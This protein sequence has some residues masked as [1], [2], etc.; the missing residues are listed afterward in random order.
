[1]NLNTLIDTIVVDQALLDGT[2]PQVIAARNGMEL[3]RFFAAN[4]RK[5]MPLWTQEEKAFLRSKIGKMTDAQIGAALGRSEAAVK[6]KRQRWGFPAHSKRPGW[7]TGHGAAKILGVDIHN[8]MALCDRRILPHVV[9]P[10][11]RGIL[12]IKKI[13]LYRWAVNPMHWI[14]FR[15]E[16]VRDRHLRRLIQLKS[17][18]WGDEWWTTGQVADYH[19]VDHTDVNR[20]IHAGKIKSVK[21]GNHWILRSEALKPGLYFYKGKGAGHDMDWSEEGDAFLVQARR[22]GLS[23]TVMA[24]LMKMD[25][26]TVGY[27][28]RSLERQGMIADLEVKFEGA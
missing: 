2:P 28:Y 18:R 10:G 6:I 17:E 27:R 26:K 7:V 22:E 1:V 13:A 16:N 11:Q 14:Y 8:I 21:W 24:R 25:E 23:Y 19:G 15:I 5:K 4:V 12:N 9:L 3:P 20:Y